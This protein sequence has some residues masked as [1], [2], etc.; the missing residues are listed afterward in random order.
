METK[1]FLLWLPMVLLA[2]GNAAIREIVLTKYFSEL[3]AHQYST[4]LLC[5]LCAV[6]IWIVYPFLH[7]QNTN[8]ALIIGVA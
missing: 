8:E 7:I 2:F 6:Y 1:Y 4:L 3:R 5:F